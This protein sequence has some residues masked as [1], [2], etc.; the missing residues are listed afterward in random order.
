[1]KVASHLVTPPVRAILSVL[2]RVE[3]GELVKIP[4]KGPLIIVVNHVNFLEVPLIYSWLYPRDSVGMAKQETWNNP[5]L[6]FLAFCWDAIPLNRQAT[7]LSAMRKAFAALEKGRIL[8]LAPEGTRSGNGRLQQ[9]HPGMVQIALNS[10]API[11]PLAHT[12][13]E[14]FWSNFKSRRRTPF[15]FKV[16]Q[17]FH[18][19][20]PRDVDGRDLPVSREIRREMTDEIMNRISILLPKAQRG[21]YPSPETA[22]QRHLCF[23]ETGEVHRT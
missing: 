19:V 8:I 1:M 16:G 20:P 10:G 5:A 22:S 9:G 13:G 12:G 14:S 6:A 18:L 4:R 7:D 3:A 15:S 21:A 23:T 17:A 2:C 11:L